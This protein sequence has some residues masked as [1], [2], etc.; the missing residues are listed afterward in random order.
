MMSTTAC[1]ALGPL[2]ALFHYCDPEPPLPKAVV[3]LKYAFISAT[4][5]MVCDVSWMSLYGA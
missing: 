1:T 4:A 5:C 2:S 3:I